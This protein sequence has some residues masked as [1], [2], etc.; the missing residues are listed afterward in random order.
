[1][2]IQLVAHITAPR[3]ARDQYLAHRGDGGWGVWRLNKDLE[4]KF[5]LAHISILWVHIA[6]HGYVLCY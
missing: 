4:V 6:Q 3:G 2:S 1:M 5:F